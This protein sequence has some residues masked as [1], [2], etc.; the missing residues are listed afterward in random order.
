MQARPM[1]PPT[2]TSIGLRRKQAFTLIELLVVIAVI[3]ILAS[4]MFP[5]GKALT[6]AKMKAR[7]QAEMTQ[8]ETAIQSYKAK[9]GNFPPDN[10][11]SP[12]LNQLYYELSGTIIT[13]TGGSARF[14][15]TLDGNSQLSAD[16]ATFITYFGPKVSGIANTTRASGDEGVFAVN[17]LKGAL[18][19]D[20]VAAL[21]SGAKVIVTSLHWPEGQAYHPVPGAAFKSMNPWR[22][23]SSNP[24][25][26]P[27]TYDLWV[28]VIID[29]KTNRFGNWR[30]DPVL[31]NKQ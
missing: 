4:M 29:G 20:Q 25:N 5:I 26:N 8:L 27:G 11:A 18:R 6:R 3:A 23:N 9:F 28:D 21:P 10:P 15:R 17:F 13:N 1:R 14:Y 16:P 7:A 12:V 31:V 24:T 22:Y 2:F 19:P 30:K